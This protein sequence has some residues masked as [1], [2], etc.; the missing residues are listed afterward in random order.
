MQ[1]WRQAVLGLALL[2]SSQLRS[3][4]RQ[5]A[6]TYADIIAYHGALCAQ[7]R[8]AGADEFALRLGKPVLTLARLADLV[9]TDAEVSRRLGLDDRARRRSSLAAA[10]R[11]SH[12]A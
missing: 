11:R 5:L 2:S 9:D 12:A 10:I 6:A 8:A 7:A 1:V 3:N 4:Y